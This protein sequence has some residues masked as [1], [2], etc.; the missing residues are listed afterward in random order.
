M[1]AVGIDIGKGR[2]AL[3]VVD[4]IGKPLCKS[5]FYEN[6][7]EETEKMLAVLAKLAPRET[8]RIGMEATGNYWFPIHDF[9]VRAGYRVDVINPIV[10]SASTAGN[11][12]G[13]RTDRTDALAIALVVLRGDIPS[14][15][16]ADAASRRLM[17]LTRHRSFL[18]R[19]RSDMKRRL[20]G[21]LAVAFPEFKSLFGRALTASM[22]ELLR[23][24]PT[25][26]AMSRARRPAV[27]KLLSKVVRGKD[28]EI[29][30]AE[31]AIEAFKPP[32]LAAIISQI[33]GSGQLL[34]KVIAAEFG[35][36]ASP[37]TIRISRPSMRSTRTESPKTTRPPRE[38]G[39]T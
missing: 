39:V 17:A 2:H 27:A 8:S 16:S 23:R 15:H 20:L 13:R 36:I 31:K 33:K 14:R 6:N 11:I 18:V 29:D 1:T 25:A 12:R 32:R 35:N 4:E 19:R 30:E 7:R 26:K 38:E 22:P 3:A 24:Y 5:T 9:L 10:T 34:P 37:S 21:C 28:A